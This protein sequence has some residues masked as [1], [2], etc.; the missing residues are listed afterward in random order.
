MA[1]KSNIKKKYELF[2]DVKG[3]ISSKRVF[4][5]ISLVAFVLLSTVSKAF[6]IHVDTNITNGIV[7][8][9]I[10]TVGGSTVEHFSEKI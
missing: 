7:A 5:F 10:S 8:I 9:F 6:G 1:E 4:G 3:N 2:R